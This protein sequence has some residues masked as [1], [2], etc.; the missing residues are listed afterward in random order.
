[1]NRIAVAAFLLAACGEGEK[2]TDAAV[3]AAEVSVALDCG[4]ARDV[5]VSGRGI[6]ALLV[7]APLDSVRRRCLVL[8]DSMS[9]DDEGNLQRQVWIRVRDDTVQAVVDSGRVWRIEIAST[10]LNTSDSLGVGSSI[11]A[12]LAAGI[13]TGA[14]GEKGLYVMLE[15]HCGVS[16]LIDTPIGEDAHR[17]SWAHQQLAQIAGTARV[18]R[19]LLFGCERTSGT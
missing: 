12:L 9:D 3:A 4:L 14:E 1:M 8:A 2:N 17:E 5:A 16:F 13:A 11:G 7:G 18:S 10:G 6:G 19:V 15:N